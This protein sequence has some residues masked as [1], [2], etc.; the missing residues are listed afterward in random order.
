MRIELTA[1]QKQRQSEIR[2][3]AG[4]YI[5]PHAGEFDRQ[6]AIPPDLFVKI[7][8]RGYFGSHV[9]KDHGG[10]GFDMITYGLL[11]EE[12]G[13]VCSSVRTLLTVHDMVVEAILRLGGERQR[14]AW[15]PMLTAGEALAAFALTEPDAGSDAAGIDTTV[16]KERNGYTL[17][18]H[19]KWISFGQIADV[20]LVVAR[21]GEKGPLGG[22]LVKRDTPGLTIT[23]M[24]GLLGLRAS[25]LAELHFD[26]CRLPGDAR[27]GSDKLPAGLLT[28]TALHL[29]RYGV[30]WGCAGIGEACLEASFRYAGERNQFG[31]PINQHQ[32]IRRM[33]TN[34]K[35][36][37]SA[38][39]LLCLQAG[40]LRTTRDPR[41]VHATL[42]AKYFASR[43]VTRV[44]ND[45][46]QIHGANG[47]SD[48]LPIERYFR[49]A[50][51][52]EII[53]GSSEILQLTIA[54]YG[55]EEYVNPEATRSLRRR[56]PGR[57]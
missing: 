12:I 5:G 39:R 46:V 28:A 8:G 52:M 21:I 35:A 11:H 50:R 36:D 2:A 54:K 48:A 13:R 3:F 55:G 7:A 1:R 37:I 6:E 18:G 10:R 15:L 47:C 41:A 38:A 53:E 49:D 19:K 57:P 4:E 51:I 25:M 44:A 31:V 26:R 17:V 20:F 30:A 14:N 43:M 34:M 23:P 27:V 33:L 16:S 24:R 42:M 32:L 40:Y 29:G 45:A 56:D 22:F 9:P